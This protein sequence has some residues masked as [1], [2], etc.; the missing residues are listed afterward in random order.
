MLN[1]NIC[2]KQLRLLSQGRYI[3]VRI[4]LRYK[5]NL[6]NLVNIGAFKL[7]VALTFLKQ[8]CNSSVINNYVRKYEKITAKGHMHISRKI[9]DIYFKK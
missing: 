7:N 8:Y 4:S 3:F 2:I 6:L 9:L 1:L 5:Y